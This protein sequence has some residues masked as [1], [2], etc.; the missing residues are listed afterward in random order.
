MLAYALVFPGRHTRLRNLAIQGREAGVIVLGAVAMFL[1][2]GLIEG[3][4]RQLVHDQ[5]AR[6]LV[7]SASLAFWTYYFGWVG[8][9]A[10]R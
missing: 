10:R 8:R 2:A 7:A 6:Y 5:V 3:F 9:G 1:V 4:F